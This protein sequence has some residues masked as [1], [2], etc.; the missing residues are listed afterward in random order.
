M[1][2]VAVIADV[3]VVDTK[4]T[5]KANNRTS[6]V[7]GATRVKT[8]AATEAVAKIKIAG[9]GVV[10][11]EAVITTR[12]TTTTSTA[13]TKAKAARG[14]KEKTR[15]ISDSSRYYYHNNRIPHT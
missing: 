11:G 1:A 13:M 2:V 7:V 9:T 12:V 6:K 14:L 10:T 8:E 5:I 15:K 3:D 4:E